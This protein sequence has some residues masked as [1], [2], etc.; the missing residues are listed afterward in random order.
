MRGTAAAVLVV[1]AF[2]ASVHEARIALANFEAVRADARMLLQGSA[3]VLSGSADA[4]AALP[5]SRPNVQTDRSTFGAFVVLFFAFN[6]GARLLA[7]EPLVRCFLPLKGPQ[8]AKFAQSVM[9]AIFYGGFSVFGVLVVS[10]HDFVWPSKNW[11]VGF[12]NGGHE[13]MRADFRCFYIMYIARYFQAGLSVCLEF[14]RKDFAEMLLHHAVT[15]V[16]TSVSYANS[17][18]RVGLIVMTLLDPADVPLHL[19][20]LCKYIAEASGRGIWQFVADRLFEV[21]GVLFFVTRIV[22]YGYVCWSAHIEGQRYF[23][24]GLPAHICYMCLY[25]LLALQVYWFYLIIKVA[26]RLASG[27]GV[28][29]PRSDDE[30]EVPTAGG[31]KTE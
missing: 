25:L 22:L 14:K 31:K 1:L 2:V 24:Y 17:W 8:V 3:T 16:V 27:K 26:V 11:W 15:V 28:E 20:K 29:D 6:W 19:A 18:N 13:L 5:K 10:S 7:V 23:E 9:E 21:F 4:I 30:E 12:Q